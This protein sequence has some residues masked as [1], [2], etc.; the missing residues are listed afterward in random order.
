MGS[1]PSA[2]GARLCCVD[3]LSIVQ[4]V[5]DAGAVMQAWLP[6]RYSCAAFIRSCV[7]AEPV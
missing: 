5:G 2:A 4:R 3:P 6:A 7:V 1:L